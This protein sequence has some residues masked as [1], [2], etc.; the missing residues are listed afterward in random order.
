MRYDYEQID[1][2]VDLPIN[3][4]THTLERFPYHWHEDI[5]ILFVLKGALEVRVNRDS[6]MLEEGEMFLVNSNELHFINTR[7]AFGK[8]QVLALQIK[9]EYLK[10]H[11]IDIE[12]K[13]FYLNSNEV[14]TAN[15]SIVNE[16][17]YLLANMMDLILNRKNLYN[18]KVEK[19]LLDLVV[20]LLEH[21]E[22]PQREKEHQDIDND[23]RLLEILKYM[24]NN[25]TEND[26]GLQDIAKEFSLNSQYLSRYFKAK[27]GMSL[28]KKL[29]SMRLN[30]SL[31]TLQTTDETVTDI[32]FKYGF[33]DSKAYYRVFKEVMGI[34]PSQYREQY[35]LEV[36]QNIPKDYLSINSRESLKNLFKHLDRKQTNHEEIIV[37][38]TYDINLSQNTKAISHS[39]K[40]LTTFGYAPHA[41]RKEFHDQ[42]QVVQQ[43]IGFEYV[44]F[45]GIF[46]DDLLVYNEK[47]DGS[48]FFNFNHIDS[49]LDILLSN[50]IKPFIEIGFM[51]RDLASTSDTIF[52][53][54]AHVSPPKNVNSWLE[55]LDAFIRHLINRYGLEEVR[56]WYFEFWNEPE[57]QYFWTGTREEFITL[58]VKSY[59]C[60]KKIDP[61]LRIGGFGNIDFLSNLS[62]L[63]EFSKY[64]EKEKI[65]LDFFSFHVYNLS[66]G[67]KETNNPIKE[68]GNVFL[69]GD[70]MKKLQE[71]K[72]VM[73]GD[74]HNITNRIDNIKNT[75]K[76]YPHMNKELWITE[77]NA[78]VNSRDLVHDTCYMASFIVKN[79]IE[80]YW[81]VKGMG[82]WTFTD[83]FEEFNFE[84][85]L[86]HGGFGLMTYNGLKKASYHAYYFLS[87]LGEELILKKDDLIVTKRG[88]DYQILI[89]NYIHPNKLY[90]SFDFSQL[91][92]TNRYTVFEND[93]KKSYSLKLD[94]IQGEYTLKKQYVNRQQGSSFDAWV[95]IGA[96]SSIDQDTMR[97]LK[98]RAEPGIKIQNISVHNEYSLQT[99]LQPHEIQLIELKKRY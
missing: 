41:L 15:L 27:V 38:K 56:S 16:M 86:F 31:M 8:T 3:I 29:D 92:M 34:T 54:N 33:P 65:E 87:K 60:I 67:S 44:R 10:K 20:I 47:L 36:E 13:R 63:E 11:R 68:F 18:L 82:F 6:Y 97:F 32:A 17:K 43:E 53:W 12:N 59:R 91:S 25:C 46:S 19:H 14:E 99:V 98:G 72:N 48:Y 30:K 83:I 1:Y 23:Q 89:F 66:K 45:H 75:M 51:P 28:K 78:S 57:V 84:Q 55:L 39:F 77:W 21:F 85:P 93:S 88:Q 9:S 5:E 61:E 2:Q 62:W 69:T 76:G 4:F 22:V 42:L 50:K 37:D 35:M 79:V 71:A 81:K 64:L 94:G 24:N 96:P 26:F 70:I 52:R 49:L 73:F 90:S 7:T 95:D 58:F 74:E 40:K 80:N